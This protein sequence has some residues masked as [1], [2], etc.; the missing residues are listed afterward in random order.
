[1]TVELAYLL[2]TAVLAASL[3]IPFIVGVNSIPDKD[4]SDFTRPPDHTAMPAWVHRA[5]RAHL[6]MIEQFVPF[7][8]IVLVGHM[9]GVSTSIT[10]IAAGAF[11]WLRVAHAVGMISGLAVFPI[12]PIIFTAGWVAILVYAWQVFAHG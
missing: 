3:W 10:A 4:F 7:A 12:R 5:F 1:M 2:A 11:F 6:N 8:A 9:L